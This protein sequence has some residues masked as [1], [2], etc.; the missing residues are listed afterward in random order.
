MKI[1]AAG[2]ILSFTLVSLTIFIFLWC[3]F[4][5]EDYL[6]MSNY[7]SLKNKFGSPNEVAL[8]KYISW[9]KKIGFMASRIYVSYERSKK[10]ESE[11]NIY[12]KKTLVVDFGFYDFVVLTHIVEQ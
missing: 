10:N 12:L 11:N 7:N 1:L 9:S 8:H 6:R 2:L 3:Y 5:S 4:G